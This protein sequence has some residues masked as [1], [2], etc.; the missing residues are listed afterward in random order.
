[1]LEQ[2]I[3]GPDGYFD[4]KDSYKLSS[5]LSFER[6]KN[7]MIYVDNTFLDENFIT[8]YSH[9]HQY[10]FV[11]DENNKYVLSAA[12]HRSPIGGR[13]EN[14][15]TVFSHTP[16]RVHK[17]AIYLGCIIRHWGHF[18]VE[19]ISR[20]WFMLND[21]QYQ[22]YEL[23]Y[24][25]SGQQRDYMNQIMDLFGLDK[26]RLRKIEVNTIYDELIIPEVSTEFKQF[27][28]EEYKQTVRRITQNIKPVYNEKIY[29][30][31]TKFGDRL[32][33][34]KVIEKTFK[35][36]GYKIIYP[37]RLSV[38]KQIAI[39]KGARKI[40]CVSGTTAHNLIFA[41]DGCECAVLE[42]SITP[43][44]AQFIINDMN[45]LKMSYIKTSY[46]F[47][48]T[49]DGYGPFLIGITPYLEQYFKENKIT[50]NPQEKDSYKQ[51]EQTYLRLWHA[52]YNN[53]EGFETILFDNPQATMSGLE[54]IR[55]KLDDNLKTVKLQIKTDK[56][57][58]EI[59]VVKPSCLRLFYKEKRGR[60]RTF[61]F[62]GIPVYHY[63]K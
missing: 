42:R 57:I 2:H 33:G 46:S 34:E 49:G 47:L 5:R 27:W 17:K 26:S 39:I 63:K 7:G 12:N 15:E 10:G 58:K 43:N 30:S 23:C 51:F 55:Q 16:A 54:Q 50:Y 56:K 20:W 45:N 9:L 11:L 38:K 31:R 37:E 44:R 36:N 6:V 1:M 59:A 24:T 41:G 32:L 40:A 21:G 13:S 8:F 48:P 25:V 14:A 19:G 28:T 18:L 60:E 4:I 53:A 29:L 61:Y 62:C 3:Y 52:C 22:D 35:R